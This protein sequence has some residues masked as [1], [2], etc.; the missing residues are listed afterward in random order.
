MGSESRLMKRYFEFLGADAKRR[1]SSSSKFWEVWIEGLSLYTRFGKIG[2]SGQTTV[3]EFPDANAALTAF[4]KAVGEKIKKGYVESAPTSTVGALS[5]SK[6]QKSGASE[7]KVWWDSEELFAVLTQSTTTSRLRFAACSSSVPILTSL[8]RDDYS[9]V[10]SEVGSNPNTPASILS[11]LSTDMN[12]NVRQAVAGNLS[13]PIPVLTALST[14]KKEVLRQAV[15]G[16]LSTPIPVLTNLSA[17]KNEYVLGGVAENPSTPIPVLT[18]L[19]AHKNE[20]VRR[21]VGENTS[22]PIPVLNALS[23]DE[24]EN[25]REGVAGNTNTPESILTNLST[26]NS[27]FVRWRVAENPSTPIPVLTTLAN[28][29]DNEESVRVWV[30]GNPSTPIPVLTALA[31]DNYGHVRRGV[32]GNPSTPISVLTTLANDNEEAVRAGVAGNPNTPVQLLKVLA[33][34]D[35]KQVRKGLLENSNSPKDLIFKALSGRGTGVEQAMPQVERSAEKDANWDE[36]GS[37]QLPIEVMN[38]FTDFRNWV[39]KAEPIGY[40][41]WSEENA[42]LV[43]SLPES[44]VA[45]DCEMPEWSWVVTGFQTD[46][47]ILGWYLCKNPYPADAYFHYT[48]WSTC[49]SCNPNELED[50]DEND[51]DPDCAFCEG[52]VEGEYTLDSLVSQL[53]PIDLIGLDDSVLTDLVERFQEMPARGDQDVEIPDSDLDSDRP[54]CSR[55]K[56][57]ITEGAKFCP[58]CGSELVPT[59]RFCVECGAKRE[60]S[61]K[62]CPDCGHQH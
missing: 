26:D 55:C 35:D 46:L 48:I 54:H 30:A 51:A 60:G 62:F 3:K 14:D 50:F 37:P 17:D 34:D 43:G 10:R 59:P 12:E 41:D 5:E 33:E 19:S 36:S 27:E 1:T 16:N 47:R 23:I 2:A 11:N 58:E 49:V 21:W 22:T 13:T 9:P 32:A 20:Y 57:P 18:N 56:A 42:S 8:A 53:G 4:D 25:V 15:A 40:V 28:D 52:E 24:N 6:S 38:L 44:Y 39:L 61:G 31:T 45:T 7:E 29:N